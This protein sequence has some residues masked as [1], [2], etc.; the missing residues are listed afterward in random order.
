MQT[1]TQIK[2]PNTAEISLFFCCPCVRLR[3]STVCG[4]ANVGSPRRCLEK[5]TT[6]TTLV[7]PSRY[8]L[9]VLTFSRYRQ[10]YFCRYLMFKTMTCNTFLLSSMLYFFAMEIFYQTEVIRFVFACRNF[11]PGMTMATEASAATS[12]SCAHSKGAS[13]CPFSSC[14]GMHCFYNKLMKHMTCLEG[15]YHSPT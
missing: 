3:P 15:H 2:G 6:A 1:R 5:S 14:L 12:T 7:P 13:S 11:V 8:P 10:V 9:R 4:M